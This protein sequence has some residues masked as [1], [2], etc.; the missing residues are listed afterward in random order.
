MRK[1]D[2]VFL[3]RGD[4][5]E[6]ALALVTAGTSVDVM[7]DRASGRSAFLSQL[8]S[9]LTDQD[10]AV[11]AVRGV[12]SLREQPFAAMHLA[13]IG[14]PSDARGVSTL[15]ATA[16]ALRQLTER[17]RSVLFID[18]WEDVDEASWGVAEAVRRV[19]GLP[20][21]RTR[22]HGRCARHT[23]SGLTASTVDPAIMVEMTP[24]RFE[25]LETVIESELGGPI[26]GGTMSRLYAKSG[27][28]IG[29]ALSMAEVA[30]REGRIQPDDDGSWAAVRDLW[31]PALS[32][33]VEAHLDGV[34]PAARDALETIALVGV[35]DL[36]TVRKL[37]DDRALEQLE[38]R[39]L[40]R[41]VPS[42]HRQ[43]V[44][45]IPPLLV[46][47]FR[48]QPAG[49]RRVRIADLIVD[50]LGT[51]D[52][53]GALLARE[54][55]VHR[56]PVDNDALIVRLLRE[57]DRARRIVAGA[58]WTTNPSAATAVRFAASMLHADPADP[59]LEKVM[60]CSESNSGEREDRA[61]FAVLRARWTAY[62]RGDVESALADLAEQSLTVGDFAA[63]LETERVAIITHSGGDHAGLCLPEAST[64][65]DAPLGVRIRMLEVQMLL[66]LTRG[67][68]ADVK[69][70]YARVARLDRNGA[71]YYSR[72]Y[73]GLA[74][75][76]LGRLDAAV[77]SMMHGLDEARGLLDIEAVRAYSAVVSCALVLTGD[78][79]A[80]D[81]VL[82]SAFAAGDPPPLPPGTQL[83]LMT[84]AA[85]VAIRRGNTTLGERYV[86]A[87]SS[88]RFAE[89]PLPAQS[90]AMASA[91]L[92]ALGDPDAAAE[93]LWRAAE[94][95]W[96]NGNRFAA[97][98]GYLS[99]LEV[100]FDEERFALASERAGELGG[101]LLE[102][103]LH[104]LRA[105]ADRDARALMAAVASLEES[106]QRGLAL[107]AARKAAMRFTEDRDAAG[108]GRA[109]EYEL[110]LGELQHPRRIHTER[111]SS[112]THSL[113]EREREVAR[114]AIEGLTNP[115]I[116]ARLVVSV[117]TVES[118]IHHLL[119]KLDIG[120][121]QALQFYADRL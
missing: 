17:P 100:L 51:S 14:A 39:A 72:V 63:L 97:C 113:S 18:D 40:I 61:E 2:P 77:A 44:T 5:L 75:V 32:T 23:P 54:S 98:Y 60:A 116:A 88:L 108:A 24:L 117:R 21:V 74:D 56:P 11:I 103:R 36:D 96:E 110:R 42:G 64:V 43:L 50:K 65:E 105:N 106:G 93:T 45:V 71:S 15:Q 49:V 25:D 81:E 34:G 52:T 4:E 22:L 119:R 30:R 16:N 68:F 41:L 27:G 7:G 111:F 26:E 80:V 83:M 91:Q 94:T 115:E 19:T 59:A 9:R 76:A 78:Y 35:A 53:I 46:E 102:S 28:S 89:G 107:T 33:L 62:V 95:A 38:E 118:H 48:H 37:V 87:I 73:A 13:G 86:R 3:G 79:D 69:R 31:S 90:S 20:M 84:C 58:E 85:L 92:Q 101:A 121:R 99:S 55:A 109:A 29:L 12:V 6:M 120:S 114:L 112:S 1:K 10:W 70:L 66:H 57:R 82:D 104:Y 8:R 67:E 47:F